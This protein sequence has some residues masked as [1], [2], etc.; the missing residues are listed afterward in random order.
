MNNAVT[1]KE[2]LQ[3]FFMVDLAE[4]AESSQG[5]SSIQRNIELFY[6]IKE[7]AEEVNPIRV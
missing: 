4:D 5:D 3:S 2:N 1:Q 6:L 7:G